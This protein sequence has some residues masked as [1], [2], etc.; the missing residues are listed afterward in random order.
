MYMLLKLALL[1]IMDLHS[2]Y[3]QTYTHTQT[4]RYMLHMHARMHIIH[5]AYGKHNIKMYI[6][7]IR[8]S[9]HIIASV[10]LTSV[11]MVGAI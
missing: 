10:V 4:C 7:Y 2:I 5:Y 1:F 11:T 8:T 6:A 3:I 9:S